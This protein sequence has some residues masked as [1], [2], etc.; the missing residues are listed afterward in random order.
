MERALGDAAESIAYFE[1]APEVLEQLVP[2]PFEIEN[3]VCC[4][5]LEITTLV[6]GGATDR[7]A[8]TVDNVDT[9][10]RMTARFQS[11]LAAI[12][13]LFGGA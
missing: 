13:L 4:W 8:A 1:V 6:C 9:I 10:N 5:C 3:A 2:P 12:M 11:T 7:K